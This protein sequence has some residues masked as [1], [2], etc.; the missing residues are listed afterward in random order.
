MACK[1]LCI[2]PFLQFDSQ[3]SPLTSNICKRV[4][5]NSRVFPPKTQITVYGL[6]QV[7][8]MTTEFHFLVIYPF[9]LQ[10]I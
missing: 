2:L 1:V 9:E 4:S 10:C 8:Y 5:V 3:F 7:Q 6:E